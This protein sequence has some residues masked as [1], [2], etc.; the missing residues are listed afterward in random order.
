MPFFTVTM[1]SGRAAD[2]KN[3]IS[4]ALHQASVSAGHSD[5][6][7]FQRF[8]CLGQDDLKIDPHYPGLAKPRTEKV[9]MIEILVSSLADADRKQRLHEQFLRR[10]PDRTADCL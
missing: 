7:M 4:P 10:R 2:E 8:L 3:A 9:L 1:K 6:D 5:D